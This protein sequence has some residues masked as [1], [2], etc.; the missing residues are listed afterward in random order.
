M[1]H[2]LQQ[3]RKQP[4]RDTLAMAMMNDRRWKSGSNS[5]PSSLH[6]GSG[7]SARVTS[8]IMGFLSC[9]AWLYIAGRLWQ[10][11]EN[12]ILLSSLLHKNANQKP[13]ILTLEDKLT[14]L[15]CKDVSKR[16]VDAEMDLTLANAEMVNL[17]DISM[18][19]WMIWKL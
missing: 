13:K 1:D 12:R 10:D 18:D 6:G 15:K 11:T 2:S 5:K 19:D 3:N 16:I 17:F 7:G 14:N 9:I 8:L 4:I